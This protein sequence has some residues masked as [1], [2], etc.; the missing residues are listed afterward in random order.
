MQQHPTGDWKELP[1]LMTE[2]GRYCLSSA[3]VDIDKEFYQ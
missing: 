1:E 2:G 3:V